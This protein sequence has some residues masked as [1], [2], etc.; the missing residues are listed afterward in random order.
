MSDATS[1]EAKQISLNQAKRDLESCLTPEARTQMRLDSES[2]RLGRLQDEADAL[3]RMDVTVLTVLD[4]EHNSGGGD[5]ASE[6]VHNQVTTVQ[7]QIDAAKAKI[8]LERRLFLDASPSVSPAVG[9]LY[10]TRTPDNQVLILFIVGYCGFLAALSA[11]LLAGAVPGQ[12]FAT[13]TMGDRVKTVA[14]LWG[15]GIL[16]A[17]LGL[18]VFT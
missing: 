2:A 13:F 4:R 1:C 14:I 9:G 17:Y 10:F 11:L 7:N 12:Y 6:I 5:G 3:W 16:L 18:F 15:A 8:R